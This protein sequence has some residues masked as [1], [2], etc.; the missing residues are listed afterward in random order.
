MRLRLALLCAALALAAATGLAQPVHLRAQGQP[1]DQVLLAM[2]RQQG[3]SFSFDAQALRGYPVWIDAKFDDAEQALAALLEGKPLRHERIGGV[4]VISA[5]P[6]PELARTDAE[7]LP[8]RLFQLNGQVLELD[9]GEPLP[10]AYL[11]AN[12]QNLVADAQGRFRLSS[13]TDSLFQL[14]VSYLGYQSLDTSTAA[15]QVA[16]LGLRPIYT[17]LA[18]VPVFDKLLEHFSTVGNQAGRL[19]LNHRVA[20]YLPGSGDNSV[21]NLLRLHGGVLAAGEQSND[22][23]VWGSYQGHSRVFFDGIA[24]F[25]LKSFSENISVLN[26]LAV[27][28]LDVRKAGFGAEKGDCVGAFVEVSGK[29]GTA[30][31]PAF[32][33][34]AN[35]Y[36]LNAQLEAP[37]GRGWGLLLAARKSY[38]QLYDEADD[39]VRTIDSLEGQ[40][41][42]VGLRPRYGFLD[43]NLKLSHEGPNGQFSL[44]AFGGA[45]DFSYDIVL[46]RPQASLVK[47]LGE[48]HANAGLGADYH[49]Q[50]P[51]GGSNRLALSHALLRVSFLDEL[52]L[53]RDRTG[54]ELF[55]RV[56]ALEN[57]IDESR[58]EFA[59]ARALGGRGQLEA[60][61]AL[62]R[63]VS[64]YSMDS[65]SG[66]EQVEQA[67]ALGAA[68][69]ATAR[70]GWAG[71]DWE[72]GLRVAQLVGQ[73][74]HWQPRLAVVRRVGQWSK[75]SAAAG[76]Y[77]QFIGKTSQL[78]DFG[79]YRYF[80]TAAGGD[81]PVPRS[82]HL[83]LAAARAKDK[84]ILSAE[85]YYRQT[86]GLS[87][88]RD[89]A[90]LGP[91]G[92]FEG[93]GRSYGLDLHLK[94][95]FGRHTAWLAYT[96][97]KTLELFEYFPD[98]HY[99]LAPHD[100]RHELKAALMLDFDPWHLSSNYVCGSGFPVT[101]ETVQY[102]QALTTAY[103][104][105]DAA[106]V[107][108][109]ALGKAR[110][111]LGLSVLNLL[112]T[113]NIKYDNFE[114]VPAY[115]SV[116]IRL[117]SEAIPR[118]LTLFASLRF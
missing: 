64:R 101:G 88:Y 57:R 91:E 33:L 47:T 24:L 116:S 100:Q 4:I 84:T 89:F 68:L 28:S 53:R 39:Q 49:W 6:A 3:L 20:K 113:R 25:G 112:D 30:A 87:R 77:A 45:D 10:Y 37:M 61:L 7:T 95:G 105:W 66:Q 107:R 62:A 103:H 102:T 99:R 56:V 82:R 41:L 73:G 59:H 14:E 58:A 90:A 78:D 16:R 38:R 35:S 12:G 42:L 5:K 65:T 21:F 26:P 13:S 104:R 70:L 86:L 27:Q 111:E 83:V 31:A 19:Q 55:S 34:A 93:A 63:D 76:L 110:G 18:A 32:E 48:Q 80:W 8:P 74:T 118:S 98:D 106:L 71:F 54:A 40:E 11:R 60:G 44:T 69:F 50:G 36:T 81:V 75:L 96:L 108:R 23:I 17:E 67:E 2:A 22:I 9:T 92:L 114:R 109:Y 46:A 97:S 51:R 1:L 115:E 52:S 29:R 43:G 94:Q 79:N 85:L 117:Y 72:A 15:G